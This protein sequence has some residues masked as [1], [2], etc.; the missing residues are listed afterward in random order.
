MS[1]TLTVYEDALQHHIRSAAFVIKKASQVALVVGVDGE[2]ILR[3]F[4]AGLHLREPFEARINVFFAARVVSSFVMC[5]RFG[6]FAQLDELDVDLHNI[7][8]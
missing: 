1:Y 5:T 7:I 8:W 6:T 2:D 3:L 4:F